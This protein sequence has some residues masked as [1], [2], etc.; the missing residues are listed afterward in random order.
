MR[1][2]H[3]FTLPLKEAPGDAEA[4][5]HKLMVRAGYVRQLAAGL[6]IYLPLGIR[7]MEKINRIIREEMNAIGGQE[8]TMPVLNPAEVWQQTGRGG[9]IGGEMVRLQGPRGPR[10]R[11]HLQRE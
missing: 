10:R 2:S 4:V 7:V 6:Y 1:Y 8:V 3:L 9:N 11:L 5:S